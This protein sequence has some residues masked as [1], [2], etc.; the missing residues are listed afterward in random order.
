VTEENLWFRIRCFAV[1]E[2]TKLPNYMEQ[3]PSSEAGSH[4]AGQEIPRLLWNPVPYSQ[5]PAT[6][7]CPEPD[8]STLQFL[9]L[10][11]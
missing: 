9:T 7:S 11:L 1:W 8:A 5:Q 3:R 2:P 4:S 10:F 6:G